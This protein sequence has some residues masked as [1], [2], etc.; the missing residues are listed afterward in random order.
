MKGKPLLSLVIYLFP[1]SINKSL[2]IFS[3]DRIHCVQLDRII[4]LGFCKIV[5][6]FNSVTAVKSI[7]A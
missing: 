7:V 3:A 2:H 5:K 1:I 6:Q 4:L